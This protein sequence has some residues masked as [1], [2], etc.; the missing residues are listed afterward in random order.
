[1][2]ISTLKKRICSECSIN[3][4]LTSSI[5]EL[6]AKNSAKVDQIMFIRK[7]FEGEKYNNSNLQVKI[8]SLNNHN[9]VITT[10]NEELTREL[11]QFF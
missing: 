7:E 10:Q 2:R 4:E 1:M 11:N 8:N 3:I 9:R 5:K 6:E